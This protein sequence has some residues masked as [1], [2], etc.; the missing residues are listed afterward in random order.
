MMDES[1]CQKLIED[2]KKKV[3][4]SY[5]G[6][7]IEKRRWFEAHFDQYNTSGNRFSIFVREG[8]PNKGFVVVDRGANGS[9]H[10]FDVN[11]HPIKLFTSEKQRNK[12][13]EK[14]NLD[15]YEKVGA[16]FRQLNERMILLST[17][18]SGMVGKNAC[19]NDMWHNIINNFN[20]IRCNIEDQFFMDYPEELKNDRN[21][22]YGIPKV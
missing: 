1:H 10:A 8:T 16:E 11:G 12:R 15:D 3:E 6:S 7:K 21:I 20:N 14:P 22:F 5:D 9:I 2:A 4:K 13:K 19:G 17:K 18:V